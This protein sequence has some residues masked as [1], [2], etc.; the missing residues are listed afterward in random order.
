MKLSKL[1]IASLLATGAMSAMATSGPSNSSNACG[2]GQA[3]ATG[4]LNVTATVLKSCELATTPVAFGAITPS[5]AG[6]TDAA[7]SVAVV[8]TKTTPYTVALSTGAHSNTYSKRN[9]IG[10]SAPD[11]LAYNLYKDAGRST[12]WGDGTGGSALVAGVGNSVHQ[13]YPVYGRLNKNQFVTPGAYSDV[14]TV[15]VCY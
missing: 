14:V 10:A 7:G 15:T 1:L 12:V 11:G 3:C 8:C 4:Q 5:Q 13:T 2:S 9:M 6:V